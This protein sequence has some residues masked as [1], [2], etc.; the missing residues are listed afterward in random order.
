MTRFSVVV[1]AYNE[2]AT[3]KVLY[4]RLVPVLDGL[5][6]TWEI[7]YVD[8]GSSDGTSAAL[9]EL[10]GDPRVRVFHQPRNLGKS[11]A[12][13]VAFEHLRGEIVFTLDADLQDEPK[14]LPNLL[15]ALDGGLDLVVGW[16]RGR[17]KNEPLKRI[18]SGVFNYLMTR[19]FG[20]DL[21][22]SNSGIRGMRRAVCDS[23]VLYGDL[24]RFIPQLSAVAG[25]RVGQIPVEHHPRL[26][27]VSKYGAKRFWTGALDLLTVRFLTRYRDQPLHFFA[28]AGAVPLVL[29]VLLELYVLTSKLLGNTFQEHVAAI[30]IGVLLILVGF[31][32]IAVGLIAELISAQLHHL[33]RRR[34]D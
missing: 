20:L 18:P 33:R 5:E 31:Q 25:F 11:A 27:G 24:Y 29:G 4:E 26:H 10:A 8:D 2:V 34:E 9:D 1:P 14:E 16:K 6:G 21:K 7:V 30:V 12:Y 28:T 3:V 13:T 32:G 17:M 22:D 19:S 15:A 23:L